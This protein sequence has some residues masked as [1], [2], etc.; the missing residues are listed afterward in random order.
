MIMFI[1]VNKI[2]VLLPNDNIK[3]LSV[4]TVQPNNAA[5]ANSTAPTIVPTSAQTA[6]G[7]LLLL[8]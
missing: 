8:A 2:F 6:P 1:S 7:K 5:V 4:C 3:H